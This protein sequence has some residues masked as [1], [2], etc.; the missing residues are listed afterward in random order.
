[1][2]REIYDRRLVKVKEKTVR[3]PARLRRRLLALRAL[4]KIA[5]PLTR[6]EGLIP[7]QQR[8]G[9]EILGSQSVTTEVMWALFPIHVAIKRYFERVFECEDKNE[10]PLAWV[11]WCVSTDLIYAFDAQPMCTEGLVALCLILDADS[12]LQV[13]DAG[14]QAGVPVEYCSASKSALGAALTGNLP[15]PDCIVTSSHPCDSIVSSYQSLEYLA[16]VPTFRLD[17]PYWD[18]DRALDYYAGEIR[19]L[20]AFLEHHFQR[21]LSWDRLRETLAEVNQTNEYIMELNEMF[22]AKP[23]PGSVFA[24]ILAWVSRVVGLGTPEITE[25][26]RRLH[27]VTRK[28]LEAGKGAIKKEKVRVIWFDVPV[29]YYPLLIWMEETFGAVIVTD[30]VSYMNTPPIDL[31]SEDAMIRG[32]AASYMNLA[33]ARQFHGPV[34]FYERDLVKICDQYEG[35]CFIF[36]GHVGCKHSAASIRILKDYMKKIG[37]PILILSCDIFDRRVTHENQLK[38]QIEE[39]FVSNRLV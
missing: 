26:S 19:R 16:R 4:G 38:A 14:E 15:T 36:A 2:M 30:V 39:F 35:D 18:D 7:L 22:R 6:F 27:Q 3:N 1:M 8:M 31:A 37:M 34:E 25:V 10:R 20:I 9:L 17:T 24:T 11:E 13:I 28:K 29:A 23:S 33:M 5:R 32:L 21:K 12:T